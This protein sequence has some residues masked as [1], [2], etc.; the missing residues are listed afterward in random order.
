MTNDLSFPPEFYQALEEFNAGEFFACHETLEELWI[1]ERDEVRHL[2]QGI[3]HIAV[4]CYHLVSRSNWTGAMR[5]LEKGLRRLE[6]WPA[7]IG[8]VRI[9][10]LREKAL[11][12]KEHL[13]ALGRE[14]M[15]EYDPSLLPHIDYRP[16]LLGT[17]PSLAE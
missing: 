11:R 12:L 8:G 1:P 3:L 4:V 14:R 6:P 9:G 16:P 13:Q 7:E 15:H 17:P 5:Q 10:K 2:Y